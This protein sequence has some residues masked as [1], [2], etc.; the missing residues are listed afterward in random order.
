MGGK[1]IS[2]EEIKNETVDL[3]F[4]FVFSFFFI[5]FV[6]FP[7]NMGKIKEAD[8]LCLF[9]FEILN[10]CFVLDVILSCMFTDPK[11]YTLLMYIFIDKFWF[12]GF[13]LLFYS[14]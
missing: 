11:N 5:Y 2:L 13:W 3:V 10:C 14:L 6:W 4:F 8:W 12:T 9:F 7:R 1:G